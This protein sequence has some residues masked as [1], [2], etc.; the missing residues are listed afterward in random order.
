MTP[1]Q[2]KVWAEAYRR[3]KGIEPPMPREEVERRVLETLIADKDGDF[4]VVKNLHVVI[5][6]GRPA[7]FFKLTPK[8]VS[9]PLG[10]IS[11]SKPKERPKERPVKKKLGNY[12]E[13]RS[14]EST[15]TITYD[16]AVRQAERL[17]DFIKNARQN[18]PEI[19]ERKMF[20][21]WSRGSQSDV[22]SLNFRE[23]QY[24][25]M[26]LNIAGWLPAPATGGGADDT[27]VNDDDEVETSGEETEAVHDPYKVD[28]DKVE[29]SGE[30]TEAVEPKVQDYEII[31]ECD[32]NRSYFTDGEPS[33]DE[34]KA[35]G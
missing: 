8:P 16:I 13:V 27:E 17:H 33:S 30:E 20:G 4:A 19:D 25:E 2:Q 5:K 1:E 23:R 21:L 12:S 29:T 32:I 6:N 15:R 22:S 35:G 24:L 26:L 34:G 9:A 11:I 18:M 7:W 28:D 31:D 3:W 14:C 10:A